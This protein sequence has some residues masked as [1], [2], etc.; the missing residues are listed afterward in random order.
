MEILDK[1]VQKTNIWIK[2]AG[3]ELKWRDPRKACTALRA[4]L[5][6]LRD[7][8]T[9]E[10]VV[11]LGAQLPTFIRGIYYEG[12]TLK[13]KPLRDQNKYGFLSAIEKAFGREN[14]LNVDTVHV[15]RSI[16]RLLNQKI[17]QGEIDDI[18]AV[19]PRPIGEFWP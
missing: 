5:H 13:R 16:F 15:A 12:W 7:R 3:A 2:D 6:A 19:L 8:V 14:A 1:A 18:R 11:Q 9:V 10:E 4:V 17:S